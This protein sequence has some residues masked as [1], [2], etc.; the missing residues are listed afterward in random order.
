VVVT[1]DGVF[2]GTTRTDGGGRFS[3]SL[4]PGGLGAGTAQHVDTLGASDGTVTAGAQFTLTRRAGAR[5]LA[6]RGNPK[7][8]RAPFEVWGFALN[9]RPRPLYLHY[10]Q[11]KTVARATLL[12]GHSGGQCGYLRTGPRRVFPFS[13]APGLWLLQIDTHKRYAFRTSGPVARIIVG[14]R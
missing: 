13:P 9:G 5:V 4:L 8:L 14:V 7:T 6:S 1:I 3:G 11:S 12:L 2:F 10:A